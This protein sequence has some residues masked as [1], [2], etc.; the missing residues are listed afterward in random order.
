MYSKVFVTL[1]LVAAAAAS[2]PDGW[3]AGASKCYQ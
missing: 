3:T 2:C 1:A